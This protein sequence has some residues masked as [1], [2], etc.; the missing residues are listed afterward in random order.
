MS[1]QHQAMTF[2][3]RHE[4]TIRRLHSLS[5]V[6]PLGAYMVVHLTTN[7]SLMN[8]VETFQR[9]V[10][11]IHSLG[12]LLPI[13]EWALILFPLLFHGLLGVWIIRTGKSNS[14]NYTFTNNRRYVWQRWTGAIA[15]VFLLTH[16]FHLHGWF[17][18]E[19]WLDLIGRAGLGGFKPYN[20][21]S[22]LM[23]QLD[24]YLW[25]AFYLVG[26]LATVYHLANGIW[27]AGITWGLWISPRAQQRATKVCVAFGVLLAVIGVTAWWAAVSPGEAEI[28]EAKQIE[29]EMYEAA[30]PLGI[31][32]DMPHKRSESLAVEEVGGGGQ[33]DGRESDGGQ[34]D[35][36][37]SDGGQ[38]DGDGGR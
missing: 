33:A 13:V 15:L 10:F 3:Q 28:A 16:V 5:G 34:S 38:S 26:M 2:F 17:H 31:V 27:T 19:P 8:G 7:A 20:A 25:P 35:G 18:F 1:D 12:K 6:V 32:Y 14:Q 4:F 22:T 36:G 11:G 37:Q 9:A 21:A 29:D 30:L 23:M 24:G